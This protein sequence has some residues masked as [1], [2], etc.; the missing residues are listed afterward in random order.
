M[1]NRPAADSAGRYVEP[2]R[3]QRVG[4]AIELGLQPGGRQQVGDER[5]RPPG[6][7]EAAAAPLLLRLHGHQGSGLRGQEGD[8]LLADG[9]LSARGQGGSTGLRSRGRPFRRLG[10]PS[11]RVAAWSARRRNRSDGVDGS[12]ASGSR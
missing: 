9:Q 11:A 1:A 3:L 2:S 5:R 6:A 8:L 12:S 10:G 7:H 4:R